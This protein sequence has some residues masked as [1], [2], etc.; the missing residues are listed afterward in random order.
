MKEYK[1]KPVF[2]PNDLDACVIVEQGQHNAWA[3]FENDEP[4][5]VFEFED[6]SEE[7]SQRMNADRMLEWC[8]KRN[9]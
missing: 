1:I 2:V 5:Y 3:V 9:K 6:S 7:M 4:V 8:L